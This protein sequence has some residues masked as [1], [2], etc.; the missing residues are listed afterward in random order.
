MRSFSESDYKLRTLRLSTIAISSVVIMEVTLGLA[1][2]SLAILSDGLHALFDALTTFVLFITTRTSLKPPDEEHMY[3][4]EKF[5]SIGGLIGGMALIGVAVLIMVESALR[6]IE[7]KPYIALELEFAGFIAIGYTFCIDF[8]RVGTLTKARRSESSTMKAGLYHA[9]ADL[10]STIIALFGFGLA[11]LGFYYGDALSSII[12]S[13]LLI[14]L[15]LRL[16]WTSGMELSDAISEDV[17]RKIREEILNAKGAYKYEKLRVRKS[18]EK[19]FIRATLKVPDYVSLE[20]A[21]ELSAKIESNIKNAIGNAEIAFHV[22][23]MGT[24]EMPTEKLIEKLATEVK[25]VKETHDVS[26]AYAKGKLYVTLH[27]QVDPRMSIEEAHEIAEKIENKVSENVE[28]L[29][30]VTVHIEP[31]STELKRGYIIDENDL[32]KII[33]RVAEKY[34]QDLQIKRIVTYIAGEKRHI[35]I[36]CIFS[37]EI[38]IGDAHEMASRAED[39]IKE[40]FAETIVTVHME[41]SKEQT[42]KS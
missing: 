34:R 22:E 35:N 29:E 16:V 31:F 13:I 28:N 25:G 2:R 41:P 39:E 15:S 42:L 27:A 4:H 23:P 19:V 20:E 37:G 5:E 18:G 38:S 21:H 1:V 11:T 10:G 6:L 8:F 12:L 26:M 33:H 17:V 36:D 40:R 24:K 32:R 7:N 30:N 14:S 3:G 9:V